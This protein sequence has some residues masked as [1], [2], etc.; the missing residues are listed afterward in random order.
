VPA[1]RRLLRSWKAIGRKLQS[2]MDQPALTAQID[3]PSRINALPKKYGRQEP[4]S[5][6]VAVDDCNKVKSGAGRS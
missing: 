5:T 4:T 2:L 3:N 1:G 6:A